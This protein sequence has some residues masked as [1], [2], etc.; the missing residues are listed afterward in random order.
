MKK[1]KKKNMRNIQIE[2]ENIIEYK[3]NIYIS[4]M[5]LPDNELSNT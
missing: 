1:K 5:C 2:R 3:K 4:L